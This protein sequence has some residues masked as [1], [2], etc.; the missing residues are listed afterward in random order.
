M[1]RLIIA[2][3]KVAI[4]MAPVV[5]ICAHRGPTPH[6]SIWGACAAGATC[7]LYSPI[8]WAKSA[9]ASGISIC[10]GQTAAQA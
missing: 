4:R 1:G 10:W 8:S 3:Q 7:D 5:T 9:S 6:M 2:S